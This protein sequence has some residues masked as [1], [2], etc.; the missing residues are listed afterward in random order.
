MPSPFFTGVNPA[1]FN[2]W[3]E[4]LEKFLRLKAFDVTIATTLDSFYKYNVVFTQ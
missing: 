3:I 2:M 1:G 4:Q